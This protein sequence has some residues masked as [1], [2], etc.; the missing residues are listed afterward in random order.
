MNCRQNVFNRRD[1][2]AGAGAAALAGLHGCRTVC[3]GRGGKGSYSVSILGDTHFDSTDR[4]TYHSM[5]R[6]EIPWKSRV[7]EREFKRNADMWAERMPRLIAAAADC[8]TD[9]AAFLLQLGDLAQGDCCDYRTHVRQLRD[10]ERACRRGME[11]LDFIVVCGNHDIREMVTKDGDRAF[12]EWY[13][14]PRVWMRREGEDAW[15]FVDFMRPDTDA[16]FAALKASD[17]ARHT[18]FVSHGPVSPTD[19]WGFYWFLYGEVCYTEERR[20]LRSELAKRNA[21]VLAGHTHCTSLMEWRGS[22]GSI[23]QF[24]ANSVWG[25]P[26]AHKAPLVADDPREFGSLYV[27]K[28]VTDAPDEHDGRYTTRT[29]AESLALMEEYAGMSRYLRW[30]SAGHCRL[31]VEPDSVDMVFY[32]G[33]SRTPAMTF[34]LA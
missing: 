28:H 6:P 25:R 1:F 23:V 11:D 14:R 27:K 30:N 19:N 10:A 7:C 33:D 26:D 18:F 8:R 34:R 29:R 21:I 17:G 15:I 9:D 2:I 12:D 22:E 20:A 24:I 3:G 31:L 32:P 13:G 4:E 5:Y 16:I